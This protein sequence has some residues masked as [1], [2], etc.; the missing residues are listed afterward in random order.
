MKQS[1]KERGSGERVSASGKKKSKF[2]VFS[3]Q[4]SVSEKRNPSPTLKN[5]GWGTRSEES[6]VCAEECEK[7]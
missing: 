2:T 4:F 1:G 6:F 7:K 5:R 3:D